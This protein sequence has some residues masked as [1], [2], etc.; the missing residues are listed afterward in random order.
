MLRRKPKKKPIT[1]KSWMRLLRLILVIRKEQK[2]QCVGSQ[3]ISRGITQHGNVIYLFLIFEKNLKTNQ[4]KIIYRKCLPKLVFST[5][6]HQVA[7]F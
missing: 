5:K 4:N 6:S 1:K 7:S 2:F 3:Q